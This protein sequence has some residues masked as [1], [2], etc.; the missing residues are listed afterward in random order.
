MRRV[1]WVGGAAA[2][3]LIAAGCGEARPAAASLDGGTGSCSGCHSG[4]GDEAPFRDRT[5]S[6]DPARN[7]V[8]A[9]DTHLHPE[10]PFGEPVLTTPLDC[11]ECHT[12]PRTVTDP[13]HLE[14]APTDIAF[15]QLAR[16]GG[17]EPVYQ[18]QGCSA[19][20]CHGN[21]PGGNRDNA[22]RWVGGANQALCGSCHGLPPQS[23]RHPEHVSAEIGCTTCHGSVGP[24]THVNGVKT[25]VLPEWDV[26]FA[27]CATACHGP[28]PW[29]SGLDQ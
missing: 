13:G 21:F 2:A 11:A 25:V 5:G 12:V 16:T 20:Y 23:G 17:A 8:G 4:P 26:Q 6:T 22:P 18:E 27:I 15:G 1:A 19:S 3:A 14:D 7:G 24:G 29:R 28:R 10:L 9:H